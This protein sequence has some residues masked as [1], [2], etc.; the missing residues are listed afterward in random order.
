[1]VLGIVICVCADFASS[2]ILFFLLFSSILFAGFYKQLE[3][4]SFKNKI[5]VSSVS[6]VKITNVA[7]VIFCFF[8]S[9]IASF[10]LLLFLQYTLKIVFGVTLC[11][12]E[13]GGYITL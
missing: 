12:T 1:M 9:L 11:V 2:L 5:N 7:K 6:W 3:K 10:I 4:Y 8:L 13:I